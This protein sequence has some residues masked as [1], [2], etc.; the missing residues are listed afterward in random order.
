[1]MTRAEAIRRFNDPNRRKEAIYSLIASPR[2]AGILANIKRENSLARSGL[3]AT[4]RK[5]H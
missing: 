2:F 4:K 3:N 5:V 1:M